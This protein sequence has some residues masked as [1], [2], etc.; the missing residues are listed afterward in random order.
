MIGH[1][2]IQDQILPLLPESGLKPLPNQFKSLES[3]PASKKQLDKVAKQLEG[4][5]LSLVIKQMQATVPKNPIFNDQTSQIF[6]GMLD[7]QLG[8]VMAQNQGFGIAKE[9]ERSVSPFHG[10]KI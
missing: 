8:K 2:N 6:V 9:I 3:Q 1:Q 5:F 7:D 4:V 10:R